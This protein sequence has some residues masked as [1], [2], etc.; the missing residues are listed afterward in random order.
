MLQ[1]RSLSRRIVK[2]AFP[3][4]GLAAAALFF[5]LPAAG[6]WVERELQ[7]RLKIELHGKFEPVLFSPSFYLRHLEFVWK[8]KVKLISGDLQV[9][10]RLG[11]LLTKNALRLELKG[12][13]LEVEFLDEWAAAQGIEKVTLR[14]FYADLDLGPEGL[15]EIFALDAEAPSFQFRIQRT[16]N[17]DKSLPSRGEKV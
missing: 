13:N 14:S 17:N 4:L 15:R 2:K 11:G 6:L 1:E 8:G 12:K 10:Y 7:A 5:I 16:E 9:K 3:F